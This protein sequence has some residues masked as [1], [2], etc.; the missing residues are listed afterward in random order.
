MNI[1]LGCFALGLLVGLALPAQAERFAGVVTQ[2]SDGDTVWVRPD[3]GGP[4]RPVRLKG[5]DAPEICQAFGQQSRDALAA[6]VLRRRVAVSGDLVD[7]HQRVLGDVKLAGQDVGQWMV[8]RG[9]AWSYRF[10]RNPG[11]YAQE[12]GE[13]RA[14]RQ[15]LWQDAEPVR[16]REFRVQHGSC[17]PR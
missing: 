2:V 8:V 4:P 3:A 12:E 16:P 14:T 5:I 6:L 9:Y 15:G 17:R 1:A 7:G 13:A 10:R 11:P